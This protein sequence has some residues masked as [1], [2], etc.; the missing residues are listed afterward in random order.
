VDDVLIVGAGPAGAVAACV[1][2]RSGVR[3]RLVDRATFPR[4]KLCGDTVNPGTLARLKSLGLAADIEARGLPVA[5]MLVTGERGVA[6]EGRYP[7]GVYGRAIVRRD[8]DWRLLQGAIDAGCQFEP[9]VS[10]RGAVVNDD[11]RGRAVSG[12]TIGAKGGEHRVGARVTIAADGRHSTIAFGLGLARHPARPRRWAIGVYYE[13]FTNGVRSPSDPRRA[14]AIEHPAGMRS[15]TVLEG[16]EIF[17][18]MHIR[19]GRYI[20]VAPI[21]GGLTNIC[22][23]RP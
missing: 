21:P 1:L 14:S 15:S 8:L 6:I 17:G 12:V 9:G 23:V 20:G 13:D 10:V 11:K 18:E 2:A 5:G 22:L 19:R 4:D 3:V 7:D 16:S